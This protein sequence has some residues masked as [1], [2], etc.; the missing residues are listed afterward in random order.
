[1]HQQHVARAQV[2][3]QV[4]GAAAEAGDGLAFEPGNEIRRAGR[5][6]QV[7]TACRPA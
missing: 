3:R 2:R 5:F 1:M 7:G 4:L 6:R